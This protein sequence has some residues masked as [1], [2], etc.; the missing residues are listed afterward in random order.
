M[1]LPPST[2]RF[3]AL[4]YLVPVIPLLGPLPEKLEN[5]PSA[6]GILLDRHGKELTH[7]PRQ[8]Y[9]RHKPTS[10]EEIP[11]HLIKATLAAEDKR[12]FDH[13]GID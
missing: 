13:P 11:D 6:H 5:P 1:I 8:D 7:F 9:F 12:F 3:L 2:P 10:L 4:L